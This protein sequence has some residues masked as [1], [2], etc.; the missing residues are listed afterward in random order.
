MLEKSY[1]GLGVPGQALVVALYLLAQLPHLALEEFV[2]WK[3]G[4]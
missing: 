4:T 1:T 2:L 3:L